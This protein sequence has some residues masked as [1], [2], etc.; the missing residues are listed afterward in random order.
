M[1][2]SGQCYDVEVLFRRGGPLAITDAN[3]ILGRLVPKFFPSIFGPNENEGLDLE[4]SKKGFEKL[5]EEINAETGGKRSLD[6]VVYGFGEN[7]FAL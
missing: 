2:L 6:E 7:I 3:L 1:L 4:A 5:V